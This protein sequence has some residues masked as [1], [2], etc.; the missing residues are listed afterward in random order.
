MR[1]VLIKPPPNFQAPAAA[2]PPLNKPILFFLPC[3]FLMH[4]FDA[5]P[6]CCTQRARAISD[7]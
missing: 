1:I 5:C 7:L 2:N 3:T 4:R 6:V